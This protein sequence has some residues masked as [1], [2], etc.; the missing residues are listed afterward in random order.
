MVMVG[1]AS[2]LR[3]CE[4]VGMN[5]GTHGRGSTGVVAL[6]PSGARIVLHKSKT[7][8]VGRGQAKWLPRG[9]N[10]CAVEALESWLARRVFK[11]GRYFARS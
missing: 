9:G 7:D 2:A 10:P 3:A 5:F 11:T 1:F 6:E 4:V 8:Q